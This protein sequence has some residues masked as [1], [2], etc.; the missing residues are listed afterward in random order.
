[1]PATC[2]LAAPS[3]PHG[4]PRADAN[5][6]DVDVSAPSA[7]IAQLDVQANAASVELRLGGSVS[8]TIEGAAMSVRVC[9]PATASLEIRTTDDF[10]FSHDLQASGLTA[11]DDGWVRAGTGPRIELTVGGTASSFTLVDEEACA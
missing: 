7:D 1:M 9:V 6:A 3:G 10:A 4:R 11:T 5:A 8:G 2:L